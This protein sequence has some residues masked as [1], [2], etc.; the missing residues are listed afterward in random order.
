M[1]S[2]L[3]VIALVGAQSAGGATSGTTVGGTITITGTDGKDELAIG[4]S[5][6]G[7]DATITVS[8]AATIAATVGSCPADTDPQT[9]R[10]TI[11]PCRI[12]TSQPVALAINLRG[13]DDLVAVADQS[14]L[15]S[16]IS[17]G[18]GAGNDIVDVLTRGDRTLKGDDGNDTLLAGGNNLG[19]SNNRPVIFDGGAGIDTAGWEAPTVVTAQGQQELGVSAS[20][21]VGTATFSGLDSSLRPATFRTDTLTAIENLSGTA[22]GDVLTGNSGPN[23]LS[24]NDGND[25]LKG[26][27]GADSLLGGDDLDNVDGGKDSDTMDGGLGI[28]EYPAGGGLDTYNTRDG[29]LESVT[30]V[31]SDVIVNDLVDKVANSTTAGCSVSTAAAKHLYDTHLSGRPARISGRE[32]ETKVS[33]P[34]LKPENCEGRLQALLG[35]RTLAHVDYR[36]RP[37]HAAKIRLPLA[38]ADLRRAAGKRIVLSAAEVDADGRDRFVSRPTRVEKL[39]PRT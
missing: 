36:L 20:L 2:A 12:N 8:P 15:A 3:A 32:L 30:C 29:Y 11:N 13:G 22:L 24:G 27:D 35:R 25:N 23:L 17:V 26:M 21:A 10:P 34:A 5:G 31:K 33:C 6:S 7:T 14:T 39:G 18:A 19:T 28:D 4:L 37:G 38:K 16:A 9:G 1:V